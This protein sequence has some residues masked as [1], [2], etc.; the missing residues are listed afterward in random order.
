MKQSINDWAKIY[1]HY[2]FHKFL[3]DY[4][5]LKVLSLTFVHF[6]LLQLNKTSEYFEK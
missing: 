4:V 6:Q 3:F 5:S 1:S 2:I